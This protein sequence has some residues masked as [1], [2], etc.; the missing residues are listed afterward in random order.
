V[1]FVWGVCVVGWGGG[2]LGGG[3]WWVAFGGGG[4]GWFWWGGG[5]LRRPGPPLGVSAKFGP[6]FDV[7][8][9]PRYRPPTRKFSE[10]SITVSQGT[11]PPLAMF[12]SPF[13]PTTLRHRSLSH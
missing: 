2:G 11:P 4:V 6:Y 3:V 8:M 10:D 9:G 7:K 13:F 1:C 5:V 12:N